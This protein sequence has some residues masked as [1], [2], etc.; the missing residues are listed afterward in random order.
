[1]GRCAGEECKYDAHSQYEVPV[2]DGTVDGR[3][4]AFAVD[5]LVEVCSPATECEVRT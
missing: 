3:R 5:D 1:M 4:L 2:I